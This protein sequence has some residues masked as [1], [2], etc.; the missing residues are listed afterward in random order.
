M[1]KRTIALAKYI[2]EKEATIR[3]TAGVFGVSKSLV[4]LELVKKLPN[5]DKQLYEQVRKV[6]DLNKAEAPIRDGFA[7][8][9]KWKAGASLCSG[10]K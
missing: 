9:R 10:Q 7:S 6:L 3:E 2:V 4:H 1:S 5:I 8:H